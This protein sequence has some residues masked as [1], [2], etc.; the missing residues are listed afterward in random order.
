MSSVSLTLLST[1]PGLEN[2]LRL[3]TTRGFPYM[4]CD[5]VGDSCFC[6][7]NGDLELCAS[8]FQ[9]STCGMVVIAGSGSILQVNTALSEIL[10]M[11]ATDMVGTHIELYSPPGD[12]PV[13]DTLL[14]ELVRLEEQPKATELSHTQ[15][16][17][18][19]NGTR[20]VCTGRASIA[21][22][23]DGAATLLYCLD[24]HQSS[25]SKRTGQGEQAE[26]ALRTVLDAI[27]EGVITSDSEGT[28]LSI[29]RGA[30]EMLGYGQYE[31]IGKNISMLMSKRD[32]GRH[33]KHMRAPADELR[34]RLLGKY[35]NVYAV[36]KKGASILVGIRVTQTTL[37]DQTVFISTLLDLREVD[38]LQSALSQART[39]VHSG[40]LAGGI[41]HNF[42]DLLT[43]ILGIGAEAL[44]AAQSGS[45][46]EEYLT[47]IL[48]AGHEA[49]NLTRQLVAHTKREVVAAKSVSINDELRSLHSEIE[50]QLGSTVELQF[51]LEEN[52]SPVRI[53]PGHLKHLVTSLASNAHDAMKGQGTLSIRTSSRKLEQK[54][55]GWNGEFRHGDYVVVT[56]TDDG[57][58]M[59]PQ[60]VKHIFEPFFSTQRDELKPGLGLASCYGIVLQNGG[61]ITATSTLGAGAS[62]VIWLPV[63]GARRKRATLKKSPPIEMSTMPERT[64]LL[65]EDDALVRKSTRRVLTSLGYTVLLATNG[66]E[67]LA[68]MT[69]HEGKIDVVITD[70]VMPEM[71]GAEL[72]AQLAERWPSQNVLFVSGH[73]EQAIDQSGLLP[74]GV[75]FLQKPFKTRELVAKLGNLLH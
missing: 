34:Q 23:R 22:D 25:T 37:G 6:M 54:P 73:T 35:R 39:L 49:A 28:I 17:Q 1:N 53:A 13:Y 21:R 16:F 65:V 64:I 71:N 46:I 20:I 43:V 7:S 60:T 24:H 67:A 26:A 48:S 62:F 51:E 57:C 59:A 30:T 9:R 11:S 3:E 19:Q 32:Q 5:K 55:R 68:T 42:N 45:P 14:M 63:A 47:D 56:F 12:I 29:N 74:N 52:L 18:H 38:R 72:A 58:G 69:S 2:D 66:V 61:S 27:T 31:V 50:S 40:G 36:D 4:L 75:S 70:L 8:I 41:A 33:E 10:G 44:E 15:T